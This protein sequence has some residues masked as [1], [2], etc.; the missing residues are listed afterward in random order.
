MMGKLAAIL[1]GQAVELHVLFGFAFF[2]ICNTLGDNR[3]NDQ[4]LT[5]T[6]REFGQNN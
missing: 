2:P 5:A 1:C 3:L 6:F 4:I